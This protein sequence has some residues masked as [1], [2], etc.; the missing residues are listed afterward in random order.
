MGDQLYQVSCNV[1]GNKYELQCIPKW[2]I[3][4]KEVVALS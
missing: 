2:R 3:R 4:V 1:V